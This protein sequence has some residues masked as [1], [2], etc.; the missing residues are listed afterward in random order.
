MVAP[1]RRIK[2]LGNGFYGSVELEYDEGLNRPCAAK[3]ITHAAFSEADFTEAQAMELGKHDNVVSVFSTDVENG[4][5]VI[6]MEYMEDGSV[7][8][9]YK[10][11][12]APVRD[13]VLIV[14]A[15]CRGIAH[16]HTVGLLHRDI[17]PANLLL[18]RTH[19]VKVS[20]FGLACEK[21]EPEGGSG[22]PYFPHLPP[23]SINDGTRTVT[24][25][26]GDVYA[27]G[28]TAYRLL[29]SDRRVRPKLETNSAIPAADAWMP[30]IHRS[31]RT[32]VSKAL[33]PDPAKRIQSASDFRHAL[34]KTRPQVNWRSFTNNSHLNSRHAW[35][36]SALDGTEW[37]AEVSRRSTDFQ[38]T[39]ERCLPA[40]AWRAQ[41]NDKQTFQT[42]AAA[43]RYG[44]TVLQRIAGQGG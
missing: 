13:A 2:H 36:G 33:H 17:K 6:R 30:Y 9:R 7:A 43:L 39:V 16:I 11:D 25:V 23:E 22:F 21:V 15:A 14:E 40:K 24:T 27:L 10:Q 38:F 31:L 35:Q 12:A 5:P 41:N 20:D 28:L 29:N 37:R 8:D 18:D 1:F 42:E 26:Q 44:A 4:T 32:A 3:Y 19:I 34:E